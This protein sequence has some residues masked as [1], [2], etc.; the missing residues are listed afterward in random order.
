MKSFPVLWLL[1]VLLALPMTAIAK[2][3]PGYYYLICRGGTSIDLSVV[4]NN[5]SMN[6]W[7][8]FDRG[9]AR[10]QANSNTL[11]PG[12]CTWADRGL[13]P[14][15]PTSAKFH[16]GAREKLS[17]D[18]RAFLLPGKNFVQ[19]STLPLAL[20]MS[21]TSNGPI[22]EIRDTVRGRSGRFDTIMRF[23]FSSSAP[24]YFTLSVKKV[25][26]RGFTPYFEVNRILKGAVT[27]D[28]INV[29][30][31]GNVRVH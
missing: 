8:A 3:E 13:N 10:Y 21:S 7:I 28:T 23:D 30:E 9:S 19:K 5:D 18:L 1:A 31:P 20:R 4:P 6:L 2:P 29:D 16:I 12:Q 15:E 11:R 27:D 26:V 25:E 24:G 17:L 14:D 22:V